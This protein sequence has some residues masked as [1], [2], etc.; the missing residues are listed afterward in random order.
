MQRAFEIS[1]Y[2]FDRE[3][4]SCGW[5]LHELAGF[6]H[7]K[8]NVRPSNGKVLKSTYD[9]AILSDL[10]QRSTIKLGQILP[11]NAKSFGK[12]GGNIDVRCSKSEVYLV[13]LRC[14]EP[15]R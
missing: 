14:I 9:T 2:S 8:S 6:I 5:L 12:F 13:W 11:N 7:S 3:P 4:V 10:F 1:K 15:A